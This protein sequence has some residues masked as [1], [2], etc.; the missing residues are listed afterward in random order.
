M[1]GLKF[2][3]GGLKATLVKLETLT[4]WK[5]AGWYYVL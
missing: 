5:L 4:E 2:G 3:L 1:N